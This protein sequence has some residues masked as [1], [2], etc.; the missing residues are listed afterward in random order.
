MLD[1]R[2]EN[3]ERADLEA[4]VADQRSEGRSLD[5][6]RDLNLAKDE[7]KRELAR[8]V[9]SL[10]NAAGGDLIYGVEDAKDGDGKNLG[11]PKAVLGVEC[12]NFDVTKQRIEAILRDNVDPRVPGIAVRAVDGFARGPVV[13]VRV[14]KSWIAPHMV[15]FQSQTHFYSRNNAGRHPLDVREIRAAFLAG[16][17]AATRVRRFRDERIGRIIAAETPVPLSDPSRGR[18][19]VH[20]CPLATEPISMDLK[21]LDEAPALLRPPARPSS[22]N[23]RYN[24]DGFVAYPAGSGPVWAYSQ[25]FRDGRFEAVATGYLEERNAPELPQLFGIAIESEVVQL[26]EMFFSALVLSGYE[27]PTS[28]MVSI[29]NVRGARIEPLS[30]HAAPWERDYAIEHETL[31]LPDVLVTTLPGDVRSALKPTFDALWQSSGWPRSPGYDEAGLWSDK[32]HR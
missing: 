12:P 18:L 31:L 27:G 21:A 28:V 1:K 9:S 23:S 24:L 22:S 25:A 32:R 7:D 17:E 15:S 8:D 29:L 14:P 16:D 13:I 19:V 10:A 5:Y 2:L 4:L 3:I 20:V 26:V 30:G 11:Y 6:K